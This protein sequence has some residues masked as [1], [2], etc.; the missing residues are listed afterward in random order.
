MLVPG[1]KAVIHHPGAALPGGRARVGWRSDVTDQMVIA[2]ARENGLSL[3]D[4]T[5]ELVNPGDRLSIFQ[6]T[7]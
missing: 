3:V 1:G 5:G 2:F 7:T 6:K 4:Q